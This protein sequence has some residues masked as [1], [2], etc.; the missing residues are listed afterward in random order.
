MALALTGQG[1]GM[2]GVVRQEQAG[3]SCCVLFIPPHPLSQRIG[4]I[5]GGMAQ[6]DL[7]VPLKS[8]KKGSNRVIA[9][10]G[11]TEMFRITG[12]DRQGAPPQAA[13]GGC[14][15]GNY[16]VTVLTMLQFY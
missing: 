3:L 2:G 10:A 1:L 5:D 15:S 16:A 12:H 8:Y 14:D 7:P 4:G 11:I 6:Q 9:A 13:G